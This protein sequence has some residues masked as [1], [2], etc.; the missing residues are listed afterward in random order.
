MD[1]ISKTKK[2]IIPKKYL[3]QNFLSENGII[4]K[5]VNAAEIRPQDTILEIGPGTGNLTA[6]L[7]VT[8]NK[9]ICIEKDPEMVEATKER[10]VD[11]HNIVVINSDALAFD[12]ITIKPPYKIAANLPFYLTAPLIRKFLESTNPPESLTVIVQK[13]VAQRISAAIPKMTLLAVSVQFYATTRIISYISK[14]CFWPV[15]K[16]DCAILRIV[17]Y[18]KEGERADKKFIDRFFR[19]VKSGFVQP[20]KQLANN[21]TKELKLDKEKTIAWLIKNNIKPNQRPETLSIS[22]WQRLTQTSPMDYNIQ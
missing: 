8:G 12:E 15:P 17:P 4:K 1:P 19:I 6:E 7:S 9:V 3:G 21:L 11:N 2:K 5:L 18:I 13:E 10:F 22:D 14:G 16:V 20:R